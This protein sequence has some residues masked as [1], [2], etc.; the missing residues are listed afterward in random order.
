MQLP[1][2]LDLANN[3]G[4]FVFRSPEEIREFG[5]SEWNA[6]NWLSDTIGRVPNPQG[7]MTELS[8]KWAQFA[9][10]MNNFN[11]SLSQ[12]NLDSAW[13]ALSSY[14]L[15]IG[16][17]PASKSSTGALVLHVRE[18][19]GDKAAVGALATILGTRFYGDDPELVRGVFAAHETLQSTGKLAR[20]SVQ[21]ALAAVLK[22]SS[23]QQQRAENKADALDQRVE[24]IEATRRR[25]FA[26]LLQAGDRARKTFSAQTIERV[27]A[28]E[29]AS[30]ASIDRIEAVQ[31]T[32]E[33]HM[34]LK[35]P[36]TYWRGKSKVHKFNARVAGAIG[37]VFASVLVIYAFCSGIDS[38]IQLVERAMKET[39]QPQVAYVVLS[40][41]VF[42]L[43]IAFWIGRLISRT[44]VSQSHLAI[45]A[46]ERATLVETYLA[47]TKDNQIS[48]DERILV[49]TSLFRA[50]SDGLVKDDGSP[51]VGLP[52]LLSR[53]ASG[54]A[55][56]ARGA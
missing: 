34:R 19:L 43:T 51:D 11:T 26:K 13:S 9:N 30:A 7:S 37:I 40:L 47:L 41:V 23:E 28:T 49:L 46:E 31:A 39:K 36:V 15:T 2:A 35:A 56:G 20:Q 3:G 18:T 5:A 29:A 54:P 55:G 38:A 42:L 8:Q 21:S 16:S 1:I 24:E 6:W 48:S 53:L 45:D 27:R 22:R 33:E 25:H 50:S 4:R 10:T 14:M 12:G 44:Y 32:F 17:I 52:G